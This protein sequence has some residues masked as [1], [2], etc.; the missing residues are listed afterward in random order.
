MFAAACRSAC[1]IAY[2]LKLT[3]HQMHYL[4]YCYYLLLLFYCRLDAFRC[5]STCALCNENK[6]ESNLKNLIAA[7]LIVH[8]RFFFGFRVQIHW[9]YRWPFLKW[10]NHFAMKL[11]CVMLKQE[12]SNTNCWN[13]AGRRLFSE[14]SLYAAIFKFHFT[15]TKEPKLE[16][17]R[18]R[19]KGHWWMEMTYKPYKWLC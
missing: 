2:L 13:K 8:I 1:D 17:N 11:F 12:K 5:L 3:L 6:F 10:E 19:T 14:T 4:S 7:A 18:P 15:R 16:E 9:S